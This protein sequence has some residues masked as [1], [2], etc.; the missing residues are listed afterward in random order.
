MEI[1]RI[2]HPTDFS[3][4]ADAALRYAIDT[5]LRFEAHLLV[6]HVVYGGRAYWDGQVVQDDGDV[7]ATLREHVEGVLS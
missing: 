1:R 7:Y 2:F 6:G 5:A 3:R 4:G